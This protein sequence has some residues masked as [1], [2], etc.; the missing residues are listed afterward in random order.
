MDDE[1]GLE[2]EEE[3]NESSLSH[4]STPRNE[5]AHK[6]F[7]FSSFGFLAREEPIPTTK[8]Q[9]ASN[10]PIQLNP[11]ESNPTQS[12]FNGDYSTHY[13]IHDTGMML[14]PLNPTL[15]SQ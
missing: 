15:L 3:K 2:N 9:P 7:G 5:Q 13:S 11:F 8:L 10:G 12:H 6:P 14:T 4:A 1:D